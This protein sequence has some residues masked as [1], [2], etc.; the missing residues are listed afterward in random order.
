MFTMTPT[1][2]FL[3]LVSFSLRT[4]SFIITDCGSNKIVED[5]EKVLG[6][7]KIVYNEKSKIKSSQQTLL[8]IWCE[9]DEVFSTCSLERD[10]NGRLSCD[11]SSTSCTERG[12]S[13]DISTS[14]KYR[15]A[16]QFNKKFG[17]NGKIYSILVSIKHL[18]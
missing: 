13:Y 18:S 10:G 9:S 15:C 5:D 3:L 17:S 7:T 16:F 4:N 14:G 6:K 12:I 2:L 11:S 8:N 1:N